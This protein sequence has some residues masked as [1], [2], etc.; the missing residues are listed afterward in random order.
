[1][2]SSSLLG[3]ENQASAA[4]ALREGKDHNGNFLITPQACAGIS[5]FPENG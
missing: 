3:K 1:L 5:I 4:F 2:E